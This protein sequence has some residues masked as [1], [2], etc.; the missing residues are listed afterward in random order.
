MSKKQIKKST[1]NGIKRLIV[2]TLK[3]HEN[4]LYN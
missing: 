4:D 2:E 1:K 3:K